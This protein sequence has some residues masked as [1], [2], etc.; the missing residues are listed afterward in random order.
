MKPR[1][2]LSIVLAILLVIFILQNI[3]DVEIQFLFWSVSSSR[4]LMVILLIAAGIVIGW[5]LSSSENRRK[6][7]DHKKV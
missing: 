1:V 3:T 2:T 5:G 7:K 4:A 6:K